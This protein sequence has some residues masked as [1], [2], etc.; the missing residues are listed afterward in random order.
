MNSSYKRRLYTNA[1]SL[2]TA[3]L[4]AFL[5]Q[6]QV[7]ADTVETANPSSP[8]ESVL[9]P[10]AS[11]A[12]PA[13][14]TETNSPALAT[15][16]TASSAETAPTNPSSPVEASPT[17]SDT[18]SPSAKPENTGAERAANA[19]PSISLSDSPV[20]MS[21][22]GTLTD[23]VK[24]QAQAAGK[25]SWTLDDKPLEEWKTWDMEKGTL[26]KDPFITVEENKNGND[27]D[28]TFTVKELFGE[29]LSLRTPNNIR[30]TYR[31]YIGEH[32]LVG[33]SADLGLT[34]RKNLTFRPYKDFHT[35]EE[36]LASIEQ[37]RAEAKTDRLVQ[38]ETLGKSAQ[39]RDM[40][41][42]IVSKDQASIDHYLS[43][44]NP[45][46]LTKPTQ[47]SARSS[48]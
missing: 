15:E 9:K 34:I 28:L 3:V 6:G 47:K 48:K 37:T 35:H 38:L 8:V 29:D 41:M 36:M 40:K 2:S 39:G 46:A 21:E 14:S 11:S 44:T 42:G 27:L 45:T 19:E 16:A 5:V 22:K 33:T 32:T 25:I 4:L 20:Y 26:S 10:E 1:L 7:A 13:T 12:S 23:T 30:R 17:A 43:S 31:N 24:N 18:T